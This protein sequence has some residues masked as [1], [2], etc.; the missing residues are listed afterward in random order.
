[1]LIFRRCVV[2]EQRSLKA[3]DYLIQVVSDTGLTVDQNLTS[4]PVRVENLVTGVLSYSKILLCSKELVQSF[5]KALGLCKTLKYVF[6]KG[7]KHWDKEKNACDHHL[8]FLP[9]TAF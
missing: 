8:P 1:M 4:I 9:P 5:Y 2:S 6:L 3:V 7:R